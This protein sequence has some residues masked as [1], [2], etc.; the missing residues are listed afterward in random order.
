[1]KW[2]CTAAAAAINPSVLCK[3]ALSHLFF[4][5]LKGEGGSVGGGSHYKNYVSSSEPAGEFCVC[6]FFVVF[7]K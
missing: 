5:L 6:V 3:F 4:C 1:M 2:D 7:F